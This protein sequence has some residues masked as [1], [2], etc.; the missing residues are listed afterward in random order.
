MKQCNADKT[1]QEHPADPESERTK[2]KSVRAFVFF[3]CEEK[4]FHLFVFSS[5]R[6]TNFPTAMVKSTFIQI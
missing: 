4:M 1:D 3:S 5:I 2:T 6:T